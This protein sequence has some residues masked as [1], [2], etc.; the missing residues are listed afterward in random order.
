MGTAPRIP[1]GPENLPLR[2][3]PLKKNVKKRKKN[4]EEACKEVRNPRPGAVK[5]ERKEERK[6]V[7]GPGWGE[8]NSGAG[9]IFVEAGNGQT[10]RSG[11]Q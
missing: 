6:K 7:E 5:R 4:K 1:I 9:Q 8:G 3:C 2:T 11:G 10:L